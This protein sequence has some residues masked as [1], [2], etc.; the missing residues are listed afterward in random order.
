M[1]MQQDYGRRHRGWLIV[2]VLGLLTAEPILSGWLGGERVGGQSLIGSHARAEAVVRVGEV[3]GRAAVE[4]QKVPELF[5]LPSDPFSYREQPLGSVSERLQISL[6][7]FPSARV[8]D[9]PLN[10]TVHCEYYRPTGAG[11]F[12]AVV[13]LHILGGDFPL[14]RLFCNRLSQSGVAA[15]LLKMPYYGPRR[16]PNGRRMISADPHETVQGMSQAICDVRR[17]VC[18]LESREEI[19]DEKLG[20]FGISLGGI[21]GA[22]AIS[23]EARLQAGCLLL[24]GGDL[25]RVVWESR[26]T[27]AI[28]QS[29]VEKG[30]T[31]EDFLQI[32]GVIDPVRYAHQARDRRI[33]ML[34]ANQDEVIPPVCTESLWK[35]FGEPEIVW[36][37]GG[38]Y[39]VARHLLGV[40]DR[41]PRFFLGEK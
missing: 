20:V 29:W 7:T 19:Q 21:T 33:L 28:R 14:A 39:T 18:W 17:T 16:S 1:T 13:V 5:R 26:E 4:E 38:H 10:N 34:N 9:E 27:A 11:P 36:Y 15:V 12:P 22:L 40:L 31:H 3:V 24:A 23:V 2:W 30:G 32:L 37:D 41:V 6:V 25:G 35:A 8:T